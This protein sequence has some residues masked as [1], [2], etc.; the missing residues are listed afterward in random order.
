[1]N[2]T[3]KVNLNKIYDLIII[4]G[5]ISGLY[6]L[7]KLSKKYPQMK[8]M[9]LESE[10]RFGG[11][12]YTFKET[13]DN[14]EYIMNLGAG[15]L[16]FHHILINQ[17]IKE[18]NLFKKIIEI[19]NSKVYIEVNNL[20]GGVKDQT[21]MKD[22]IMRKLYTFFNSTKITK[23]GK[24]LQKMYLIDL[25]TTYFGSHFSEKVLSIFEYSS[26]LTKFNAYDAIEYFKY[27]YHTNSK[28]FTLGGGLGEII[29]NLLLSIKKTVSYR[30]SNIKI[31]NLSY[32]DN[33]T[34]KNNLFN[35]NVKNLK[36]DYTIYSKYII[37]A[38]PG[39]SLKKFDIFKPFLKD[40]NSINNIN[41]LRI[42]E[43]YDKENGKMWFENIQKTITN[44]EVQFIIPV[45]SD[46][47]LIMS[48][49]SD[50]ENANYWKIMETKKGIDYLKEKLNKK[51]N[52]IFSIY[53]IKIPKSKYIKTYFWEAG[54]A[55][56]KKNVDSEYLSEKL[57]NP[58]PHLYIIG[59][60]YSK[61]QAWCEGALMTSEKC[62]EKLSKELNYSN[63][64]K[65]T[66][67]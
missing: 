5:G 63:K 30:R 52:E 16:G 17:L 47:G 27:D 55:Y 38:L 21:K 20:D 58:L 46:N 59:E 18:L 50:C 43:I 35:V 6:T 1:M 42:Y 26:D 32:V 9:L 40:L 64:T 12:I 11:R 41:L 65:K 7:Y 45:N 49:Y 4:G 33:I 57:L 54:V 28:F 22:Y 15:R 3:K 24:Y 53:N 51:L 61:Y 25:I 8:I 34:Y 48:S 67:K 19:P 39:D 29:D 2:K 36:N 60:N 44:N 56:W 10:E 14:T 31:A 37:C 62:I 23:L 13:I 66:N